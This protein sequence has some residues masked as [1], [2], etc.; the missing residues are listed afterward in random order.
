MGPVY[1]AVLKITDQ[2]SWLST[3]ILSRSLSYA[4]YERTILRSATH[5][6]VGRSGPTNRRPVMCRV[7]SANVLW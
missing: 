6:Y 1:A 5:I 4:W 7:T 2:A 3:G